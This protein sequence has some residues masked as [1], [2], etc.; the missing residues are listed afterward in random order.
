MQRFLPISPG[1][2]EKDR[3]ILEFAQEFALAG[4]RVLLLRELHLSAT[5]LERLV[6]SIL[7][8]LPEIQ[9]HDR[10]QG[11]RAL[12]RTGIVGLHLPAGVDLDPVREEVP[13]RLGVSA[14]SR[15]ALQ[16]AAAAGADYALL[17]P[18]YKPGSKPLDV[19]SLL[20]AWKA[21]RAWKGVEIPVFALGGMTPPRMQTCRRRGAYG[22]AG[23]TGVFES[24]EGP[25]AAL[26]AFL[27]VG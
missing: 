26:R 24:P 12:A 13:G 15:R 3:Q 2:H 14:H 10:I 21:S 18:V 22:A 16:A 19:R 7:P 1:Q 17:S 23:I 25:Q 20:G 11:A 5:A 4:G 9:V 27:A 6:E 8:L